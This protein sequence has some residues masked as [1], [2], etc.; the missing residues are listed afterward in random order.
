MPIKGLIS[1]QDYLETCFKNE[2]LYELLPEDRRDSLLTIPLATIW[3]L[4][5]WLIQTSLIL[6]R[7]HYSYA[8][9]ITSILFLPLLFGVSF[10]VLVL[11]FLFRHI[12]V[13]LQG[14]T[15]DL[16]QYVSLIG[17]YFLV[18]F[19]ALLI[20]GTAIYLESF[21]IL[22]LQFILSILAM[23]IA[24]LLNAQKSRVRLLLEFFRSA[25]K[26]LIRSAALMFILLPVL[27]AIIV[28]SVFSSDLW[29][30]IGNL[31]YGRLVAGTALLLLPILFLVVGTLRQ[32]ARTIVGGVPALPDI[33]STAAKY[34]LLK[35]S[36]ERGLISAE[37]WR[38]VNDELSW[39][40]L[41]RLG[42]T[43]V[44]AIRA[45][46]QHWLILLLAITCLLVALTFFGYFFVLFRTLLLPTVIAQWVGITV[47]TSDHV[48]SIFGRTLIFRTHSTDVAVL[49]VCWMLSV[50]ITLASTVYALTDEGA[51]E[52]ITTWLRE[53][54]KTW[55]A[56]AVVYDAVLCPG[57]QTWR[58]VR[59]DKKRGL[60]NLFIVVPL[61]STSDQVKIACE[62]LESRLTRYKNLVYITAFEQNNRET[63]DTWISGRRWQLINNKKT[64]SRSF[65]YLDVTDDDVTSQPFLGLE[66]LDAGKAIPDEWFGSGSQDTAI[67]REIWES[68]NDHVI[69]HPYVVCTSSAAFVT[70][71]MRKRLPNSEQYKQFMKHLFNLISKRLAAETSI[72]ID[73]SF[74]ESEEA[75][76]SVWFN[77]GMARVIYK[78]EIKGQKAEAVSLWRS[79]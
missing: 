22:A 66:C 61:N 23:A 39:R 45:K 12:K 47:E 79:S 65:D 24:I 5:L 56:F 29:S 6:W 30:A 13:I 36:L 33:L 27:L 78:D 10:V 77:P 73:I 16:T 50:F 20:A 32:M 17:L 44:P 31:S 69:L 35:K 18:I 58:I 2:G 25:W 34:P 26:L 40:H 28:L 71:R 4:L 43:F 9:W 74:R 72:N 42:K 3:F 63:Y 1:L 7:T 68:D 41:D 15:P 64:N 21:L 67:G 54:A 62:N 48:M 55:L 51:A 46:V 8:G 38:D 60:I 11:F 70:V 76:A 14:K 52:Q 75:L 53:R 37:E 59:A 19:P 49:K 57:Y